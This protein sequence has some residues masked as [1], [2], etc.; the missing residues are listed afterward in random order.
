MLRHLSLPLLIA[1]ALLPA[2]PALAQ[3]HAP[4]PPTPGA[5]LPAWDQLSPAQREAVL[6][7]L[8]DRWNGAD[9]G[10]RQ[11]MLAHG[12]RWQSMS[13]EERDKAR[14]GL[15]RF[16]HMSPEQR[17]QARALFGQMRQLPPAQRDALRDRW[18]RMTP[19]ERRDWVRDN[20]PPAKPR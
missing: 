8:R 20:P 3:T 17:E 5:P 11:R 4:A 7:P 9:A 6:A 10:Q 18:S 13:P 2:A 12:Q 14:R 1:L 16:E 19:E 15:R